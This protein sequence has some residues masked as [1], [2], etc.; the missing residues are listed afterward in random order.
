[1]P[2]TI[3]HFTAPGPA[4]PM[5]VSPP[6]PSETALVAIS[7]VIDVTGESFPRSLT[8]LHCVLRR[9][10]RCRRRSLF[11]ERRTDELLGLGAAD[12][13]DHGIRIPP[14]LLFGPIAKNSSIF[15]TGR[16]LDRWR[17]HASEMVLGMMSRPGPQSSPIEQQ[18]LRNHAQ[19]NGVSLFKCLDIKPVVSARISRW[20]PFVAFVNRK[21]GG[22]GAIRRWPRRYRFPERYAKTPQEADD[23]VTFMSGGSPEFA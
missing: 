22:R 21:W 20:P 18:T 10:L 4:E 6:F 5:I 9:R 1:M 15:L 17:V 7:V 8:E 23:I 2:I 11:G 3:G 19:T 12:A 13:T 14:P 16:G